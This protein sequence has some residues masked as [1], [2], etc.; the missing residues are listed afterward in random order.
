M[1]KEE[2]DS[3]VIDHAIRI[4]F[5]ET[6]RAYIRPATHYASDSCDADLPAMGERFRLEA[7]YDLSGMTGDARVIATALKQYGAIVADNGSNWFI[8]GSTDQRWDD[9]DLNQL[10][11]IPGSAF[12]VVR[13][14]RPTI[15]AC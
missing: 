2:V 8:S 7:G 3:G 13:P 11:E 6:R 9:D 10:K 15:D 14:L 5:E 4:T 1:T 12:E